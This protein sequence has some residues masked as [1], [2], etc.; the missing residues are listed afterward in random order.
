L[1]EVIE[2]TG[3]LR[4]LMET[5]DNDL[6]FPDEPILCPGRR[7]LDDGAQSF[8]HFDRALPVQGIPDRPF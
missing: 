2:K 1:K 5:P 8:R 3:D 6:D 4:A 7:I